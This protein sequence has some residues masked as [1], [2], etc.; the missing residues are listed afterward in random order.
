MMEGEGTMLRGKKCQKS[1]N[2]VITVRR[3]GMLEEEEG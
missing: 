2:K 3:D 1:R